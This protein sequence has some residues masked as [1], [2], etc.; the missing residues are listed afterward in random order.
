[1]DDNSGDQV[2]S[3]LLELNTP[4]LVDFIWGHELSL[5][6]KERK[7]TN[8]SA[9]TTHQNGTGSFGENITA[10][11]HDLV[12]TVIHETPVAT[13]YPYTQFQSDAQILNDGSGQTFH[14]LS[15][16]AVQHYMPGE[17]QE[18]YYTSQSVEEALTIYT[19][20]GV[21]YSDHQRVAEDISPNL[22]RI[23]TILPTNSHFEHESFQQL[24]ANRSTAEN[25][26]RLS[27]EQLMEKINDPSVPADM[28][29]RYKN[30]L[31][32]RKHREVRKKSQGNKEQELKKLADENHKLQQQYFKMCDDRIKLL[33]LLHNL[34]DDDIHVSTLRR[35]EIRNRLR[36]FSNID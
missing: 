30:N 2:P 35:K 5:E 11:P 6:D 25:I 28:R 29:K 7:S 8:E 23:G 17:V 21:E 33:T 24:N 3:D 19:D 36:S 16:V 1:M 26:Q 32:C 22:P 14:N 15:S 27:R 20:N 9:I 10:Q 31:A 4:Q 18:G 12:T 34:K 13:P